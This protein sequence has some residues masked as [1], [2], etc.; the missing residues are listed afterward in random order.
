MEAEER[1]GVGDGGE[2]LRREVEVEE[3]GEGGGRR[4]RRRLKWRK[5]AVVEVWGGG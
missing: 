3:R 2:R 1:G 5:E 4:W